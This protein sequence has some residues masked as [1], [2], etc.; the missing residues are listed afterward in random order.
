VIRKRGSETNGLGDLVGHH[1]RPT[2]NGEAAKRKVPAAFVEANER[3]RREAEARKANSKT[4]DGAPEVGPVELAVQLAE[5]LPRPHHHPDER[6]AA[7]RAALIPIR[8]AR[9]SPTVPGQA[10]LRRLCPALVSLPAHR[11]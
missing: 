3:R 5:R 9:W 4:V 8:D 11:P 10:R 7:D 1:D 2:P 6:H